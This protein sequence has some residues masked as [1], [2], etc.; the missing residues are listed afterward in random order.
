MFFNVFCFLFFEKELGKLT[1]N[2]KVDFNV[3]LCV[4]ID[5]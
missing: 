3:A 4:Q 1:K 2:K 5:V